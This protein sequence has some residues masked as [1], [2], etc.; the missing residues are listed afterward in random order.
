MGSYLADKRVCVTGGGGF[1]GRVVCRRLQEQGVGELIAPR[2][3]RYD[4]TD[5]QDVADL[6]K[7]TEPE[8]VVHL[9]A[10]VGGI[11]ANEQHPGR[12]IYTNLAMGLHLIEAS[13]RS[14]VEKFV[15]IGAA[16]AYPNRGKTPFR[17]ADLWD[18]YP[19][20]TAAPYGVAK[21][22]LG[23]VLD[24]YRREYGLAGVHL[25]P[26]NLYGPADNFNL[27]YCHVIPA[28]IRKFVDAVDGGH[29]SVRLWGTGKA[30]REF[31]YVDDA[32]DAIVAATTRYDGPEPINLASGHEMT[33]G[34]LATLIGRFCG[35]RG[36]IVW[37]KKR[38]DGQPRRRLDATRAFDLLHWRAKVDL[39]TGLER[40][41]EWWRS[42]R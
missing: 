21:R 15:Q 38:P 37:D 2:S 42:H 40:T 16:S 28:M 36:S 7:A 23:V 33:M 22:T 9:A 20:E 39:E 35:Y 5:A 8:V 29:D 3:S 18:G 31:L 27:D 32:A 10:D 13:R 24:A 17:E 26:A 14:G 30:S 11:G 25:I 6:F 34:D 12:F 41:I 4:L 19:E 1:L